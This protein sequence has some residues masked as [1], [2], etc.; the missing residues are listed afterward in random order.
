[1]QLRRLGIPGLTATVRYIS[2][3]NVDTGQG[4]EGRDRERD[5]D[6]GYAVQSG[7]FKGLGIRVRNAM[8]RSNY[9]SDIDENRL[10]LV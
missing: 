9:R 7:V 8:A 1:L 2:G 5:I 3:D 6:L 10:I 4:F